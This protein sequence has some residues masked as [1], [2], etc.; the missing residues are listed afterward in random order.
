MEKDSK[1]T[2]IQKEEK[3]TTITQANDQLHRVCIKLF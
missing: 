2:T 1:S 3:K